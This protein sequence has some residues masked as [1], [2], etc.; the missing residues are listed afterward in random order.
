MN[1]GKGNEA[2][3]EL[4]EG[5]ARHLKRAVF[6]NKALQSKHSALLR[7]HGSCGLKPVLS[8]E[9]DTK[10]WEKHTICM[11]SASIVTD[12]ALVGTVGAR[13]WPLQHSMPECSLFSILFRV[14]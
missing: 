1:M 9:K 7:K 10:R 5:Q 6:T 8:N 12:K 2:L 13:G 4:T 3:D 14:C 11:V